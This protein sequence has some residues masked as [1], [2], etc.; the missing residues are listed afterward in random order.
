MRKA[1][2]AAAATAACMIGMTAPASANEADKQAIRK[3]LE[4]V[5]SAEKGD[6]LAPYYAPGVVLFDGQLPDVYRGKETLLKNFSAQLANMK[7]IKVEIEEFTAETR[8]DIGYAYGRQH[9]VINLKDGTEMRVRFRLTDIL[10]KIDG[11]WM[12]IHEHISYP[13]DPATGKTVFESPR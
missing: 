11:K 10:Q 7:S 1:F 2:I 3:V 5:A 13:A 12:I 4:G 6:D 9:A 8:G